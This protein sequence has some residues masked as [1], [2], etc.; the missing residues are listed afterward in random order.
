MDYISEIAKM[1]A[2][3]KLVNNYANGEDII[4][5]EIIDNVASLTS[6]SNDGFRGREQIVFH[7][8]K[9]VAQSFPLPINLKMNISLHDK[10]NDREGLFVFS[11][12]KHQKQFLLPDLYA[13]M[14]YS[15]KID[16]MDNI[17]IHDKQHGAIFIGSSTGDL[18]AI[19]NERL[20][21]CNYYKNHNFIKCYISNVCQISHN[22][23]SF[24]YPEYNF[25][26]KRHMQLSEQLIYKYVISVD[27]NT[28]AWDRVPWTL[29]SNSVS[30]KKKSET[31]CWYY[32]AMK[33][34]I[35]YIEFGD[36]SEI[37][38]IVNNTSN[39]TREEIVK[40]ANKFVDDYI[41]VHNQ[42][43]YLG[44]LLHYCS[45]NQ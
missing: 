12:F 15:S 32:T 29:N 2:S 4:E 5:I 7:F 25:F 27:G 33:P 6:S 22:D 37:I 20:Q 16:R 44:Y 10:E 30:L 11:K 39:K 1:H 43:M 45:T 13:M 31:E 41:R 18:N 42:Q 35:H 14:E 28:C 34:D 36:N 17:S 21:L 3:H 26:L 40:N 8:I 38:D 23:V 9:N 24:V 19:V